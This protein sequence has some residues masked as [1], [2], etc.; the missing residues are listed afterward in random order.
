VSFTKILTDDAVSSWK[1]NIQQCVRSNCEKL[2]KLCAIK[3]DDP[4]F[5][6]LLSMAFNPNNK[7]HTFNASRTCEGL[8]VTTSSSSVGQGSTQEAEVYAKSQDHRTP[9]GWLVHLINV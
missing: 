4:R 8:S 6:H 1:N 7:F 9:R 2:V 5:L 3:L